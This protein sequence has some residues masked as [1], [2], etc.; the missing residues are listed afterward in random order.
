MIWFFGQSGYYI[1]ISSVKN[2]S[3]SYIPS[4]DIMSDIDMK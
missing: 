4:W 1:F 2:I 3:I